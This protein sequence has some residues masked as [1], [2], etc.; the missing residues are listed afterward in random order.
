MMLEAS[1]TESVACNL[2]G[3]ADAAVLPRATARLVL[4]EPPRVVRCQRCGF[5]VINY[6]PGG[7]VVGW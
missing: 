1:D 3:A 5:M 2:C 4:P 7:P 6:V